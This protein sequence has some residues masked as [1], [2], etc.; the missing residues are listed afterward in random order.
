MI[1]VMS[2]PEGGKRPPA[3]L[4]LMWERYPMAFNVTVQAAGHPKTS[5]PGAVGEYTRHTITSIVLTWGIR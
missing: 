3:H 2:E 5:L 4:F 1:T